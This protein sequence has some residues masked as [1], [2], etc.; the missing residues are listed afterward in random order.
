MQ[1]S[2]VGRPNA[3]VSVVCSGRAALLDV[4]RIADNVDIPSWNL[5]AGLYF[6]QPLHNNAFAT[7]RP[8]STSHWSPTILLTSIGRSSTTLSLPSTI[9]LVRPRGSRVTAFWGTRMA[10]FATP[11]AKSA[12]TYIPGSNT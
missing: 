9:T 2:W 5:D 6:L 8:D 4:R 11:R 7:S 1:T 12:R 10:L 3:L